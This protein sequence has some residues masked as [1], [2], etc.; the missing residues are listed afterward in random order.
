MFKIFRDADGA[1]RNMIN[2]LGGQARAY[3]IPA[4]ST[5]TL[6]TSGL[7][8][9]PMAGRGAHGGG[10][11]TAGQLQTIRQWIE[12]APMPFDRQ[13]MGSAERVVERRNRC[14]IFSSC[15]PATGLV[16]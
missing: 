9:W 4:E 1:Y 8:C 7:L 11:F 5:A 16:R 15:C 12:D 13:L 14:R 2:T 3:V 10:M 6:N